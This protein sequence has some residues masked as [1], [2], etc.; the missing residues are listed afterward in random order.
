MKAIVLADKIELISESRGDAATIKLITRNMHIALSSAGVEHLGNGETVERMTICAG[1]RPDALTESDTVKELK[2][3][4][5]RV[6]SLEHL[7]DAIPECPAHGK[8]C[9]PY[10]MEWIDKAKAAS[11]W[12]TV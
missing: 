1:I 2:L 7:L 9:I 5:Q 11:A 8:G 6:A 3:T 12:G 4:N 10:A